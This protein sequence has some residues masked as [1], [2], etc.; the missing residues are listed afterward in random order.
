MAD[1][2][3]GTSPYWFRF[4][5]WPP[6]QGGTARAATIDTWLYVFQVH[7]KEARL[8]AEVLLRAEA[9]DPDT[10]RVQRE[11]YCP[12]DLKQHKGQ[13]PRPVTEPGQDAVWLD[14]DDNHVLEEAQHYILCSPFQLPWS[15]IEKLATTSDPKKF[16]KLAHDERGLRMV[17][18]DHKNTRRGP[19]GKVRIKAIWSPWGQA[20]ALSHAFR[21]KLVEWKTRAM[22]EER[23]QWRTLLAAIDMM[24]R[25]RAFK[26]LLDEDEYTRVYR[27]LLA[28]DQL[29]SEVEQS[30]EEVVTFLQSPAMQ[31][32]ELDAA[33][34][35]DPDQR[36]AFAAIRLAVEKELPQTQIGRKYRAEWFPKNHQLLLFDASAGQKVVRKSAKAVWYWAKS[37]ADVAA[38]YPAS[39]KRAGQVPRIFVEYARKQAYL[40]TGVHLLADCGWF[41]T[42]AEERAKQV[43]LPEEFEAWNKRR[44]TIDPPDA[45][46]PAW[47]S[48]LE[49]LE[50]I[51]MKFDQDGVKRLKEKV[52]E[53]PWFNGVFLLIDAVNV[54][55]TMRELFDDGSKDG[56]DKLRKAAS[57][58]SGIC[59]FL[60]SALGMAKSKTVH[61]GPAEIAKLTSARSTSLEANAL[62]T[63]YE[64]QGALRRGVAKASSIKILSSGLSAVG[65]VA[66]VV[67]YGVEIGKGLHEARTG[68]SPDRIWLWPGL[69]TIGSAAAIISYTA[70]AGTPGGAVLLAAGTLIGGIATAG[71]VFWPGMVSSDTDKWLMHSFVGKHRKEYIN[72]KE[73]FTSGKLL[74]DYHSNLDLQI[75]AIDPVLFDF[76][77]TCQIYDDHGRPRL[78]IDV[79]FRQLKCRSKVRLKVFGK[80]NGKWGQ[81]LHRDDWRPVG[82]TEEDERTHTRKERAA[83][84]LEGVAAEGFDEMKITLQ[85]DVLGDGSFLYPEDP[86]EVS[87]KA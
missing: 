21:T 36:D 28:D 10:G 13:S 49:G 72:E 41:E 75:A 83:R 43:L 17:R 77:P 7:K 54:T 42:V 66:D 38:G 20:L 62:L 73:T 44:W 31:A 15:R 76:E 33:A 63:T 59:S 34:T 4:I 6:G 30:A 19:G 26:N 12:V 11:T 8:Y 5:D 1:A 67:S 35:N 51:P 85:I 78:K 79:A 45:P 23:Q 24:N 46:A 40:F 52:N 22:T 47:A 32:M 14:D 50:P 70:L 39:S 74:G 3:V 55:F 69:G 29:F 9:K 56:S 16:R 71:S 82:K 65:A 61:L 25:G 27:L 58:A 87:A 86:K 48:K 2:R 53:N 80:L 81:V 60:T 84:Y 18:L 37:W 64:S 68:D 57:A